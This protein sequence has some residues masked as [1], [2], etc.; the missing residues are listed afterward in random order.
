MGIAPHL[1]TRTQ[2]DRATC[3]GQHTALPTLWEGPAASRELKEP[4]QDACLHWGL[5]LPA[6]SLEISNLSFSGGLDLFPG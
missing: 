5:P 4:D 2:A 3:T 1:L 6:S